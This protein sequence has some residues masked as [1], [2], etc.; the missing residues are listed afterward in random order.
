M[1]K[2]SLYTTF[3]FFLILVQGKSFGKREKKKTF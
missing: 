2:Y 3:T 1:I